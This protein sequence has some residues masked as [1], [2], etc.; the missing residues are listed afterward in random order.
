MNESLVSP[1]AHNGTLHAASVSDGAVS[2]ERP[3]I[4]EFV[5][6]S[7]ETIADAVRRAL[8]RASQSLRTL[9]GAGVVVIPQI[10]REGPAPRYRVTLRVTAGAL[11]AGRSPMPEQLSTPV[12]RPQHVD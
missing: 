7:D 1:G 6:A 4:V 5:G 8:T 12:D 11:V 9:E 2:A 3:A 10:C